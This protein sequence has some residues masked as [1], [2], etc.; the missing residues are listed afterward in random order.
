[1]DRRIREIY[2]FINDFWKVIRENAVIPDN[3]DDK[4]WEKIVDTSERLARKYKYDT[5]EGRFIGACIMAWL[6]Y[7]NERNKENMKRRTV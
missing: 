4:A 1:M 3:N 6:S 7:L 5:A 2:S